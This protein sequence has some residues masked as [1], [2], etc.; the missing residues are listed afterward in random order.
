MNTSSKSPKIPMNLPENTVRE[1][2]FHDPWKEPI[3][4][5]I[6]IESIDQLEKKWY[7]CNNESPYPWAHLIS[8]MSSFNASFIVFLIYHRYIIL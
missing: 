2:A 5:L 1:S 7:L 3:E 4:I 6:G 8:F